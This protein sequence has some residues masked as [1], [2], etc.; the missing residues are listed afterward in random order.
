MRRGWKIL[1]GAV[2]AIVVLLGLNAV[3]TGEQ[4]KQAE[5]TVAG[6]EIVKLPETAALVLTFATGGQKAS[7]QAARRHEMQK[8][9]QNRSAVR[10]QP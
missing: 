4:T 9:L 8:R 6:G 2:V 1:I 5:V 7:K 10:K 3:V